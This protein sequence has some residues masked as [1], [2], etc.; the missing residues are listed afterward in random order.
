MAVHRP[1]LDSL[2]NMGTHIAERVSKPVEQIK[3][4]RDALWIN[5][6]V[7]IK[8]TDLPA[9]LAIK[10][11]SGG[12]ATRFIPSESQPPLVTSSGTERTIRHHLDSIASQINWHYRIENDVVIFSQVT[13]QSWLINSPPGVLSANLTTESSSGI[14]STNNLFLNANAYEELQH[15][16]GALM[17]TDS[18][19]FESFSVNPSAN[20]VTV[21]G[22]PATIAVA[23]DLIKKFD[24]QTSRLAVIDYTFYRLDRTK[25]ASRSLDIDLLK[26]AGING[27]AVTGTFEGAAAISSTSTPF[28]LTLAREGGRLSGSSAVFQMLQRHGKVS[29]LD[30]NKIVVSNNQVTEIGNRNVEPYLRQLTG[31]VSSGVGISSVPEVD[32]EEAFTGSTIKLLPTMTDDEISIRLDIVESQVLGFRQINVDGGANGGSTQIEVPRS[33]EVKYSFPF[34]LK[35][36]QTMMVAGL[37]SKEL[38][39][40]RDRN[41]LLFWFGD[42]RRK[43]KAFSETILVARAQIL[44]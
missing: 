35:N 3:T 10:Q 37:Q 29:V 17:G 2:N 44:N 19:S 41:P 1:H 5:K 4:P 12:H 23:N 22:T 36:G 40:R 25:D 18:A 24:D 8:Y 39:V 11:A 43:A 21:T 34:R 42:A 32:I 7:S 30:R 16:L 9:D 33:Q 13:T 15:S 26:A 14:G 31:S 20:L 38:E 27:L 28:G 6:A